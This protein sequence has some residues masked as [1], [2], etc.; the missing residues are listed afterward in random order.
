ML[1]ISILGF[2][3]GAHR[4][5]L[6]QT[7]ALDSFHVYIYCTHSRKGP[8]WESS[9]LGRYRKLYGSVPVIAK[10]KNREPEVV[11]G[12]CVVIS[13]SSLPPSS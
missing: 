2:V 9:L 7:L 4:T 11:N 10:F 8:F 3:V 13:S 5:F 6:L 12:V 1:S